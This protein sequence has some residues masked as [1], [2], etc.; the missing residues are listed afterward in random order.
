[1]S[2]NLM[3]SFYYDKIK[4]VKK[5]VFCDFKRIVIS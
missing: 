4:E 3:I 2:I 5:N 1:M